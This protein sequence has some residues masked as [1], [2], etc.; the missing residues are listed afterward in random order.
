MT[1]TTTLDS[2]IAHDASD[3]LGAAATLPSQ[4]TDGLER[5][6]RV[7]EQVEAAWPGDRFATPRTLVRYISRRCPA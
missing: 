6:R 4:L 5:A 7:R 2:L 3:M 1:S